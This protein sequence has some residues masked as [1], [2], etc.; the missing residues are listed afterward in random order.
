[1]RPFRE[2]EKVAFEPLTN[3]FVDKKEAAENR[4]NEFWGEL[5]ESL[6]AKVG[7]VYDPH[8]SRNLIK[9]EILDYLKRSTAA[10]SNGT[11]KGISLWAWSDESVWE[12]IKFIVAFD[13]D[14]EYLEEDDEVEDGF[15]ES[16]SL[17]DE[18]GFRYDVIKECNSYI[19]EGAALCKR[20]DSPAYDTWIEAMIT[21]NDRYEGATPYKAVDLIAKA[22]P[23]TWADLCTF[24]HM[25]PPQNEKKKTAK[26][27]KAKK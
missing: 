1:M 22:H 25:N 10:L 6:Q 27:K 15:M 12:N 3:C 20:I 4:S 24:I 13:M 17:D 18:A 21:L 8:Y 23:R 26:K 11:E 7:K 19:L 9:K 5:E 2:P 14:Y 16:D